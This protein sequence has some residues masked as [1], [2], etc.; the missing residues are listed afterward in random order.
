[1]NKRQ[2]LPRG[3]SH[4]YYTNR[5]RPLGYPVRTNR[6]GGQD[7]AEGGEDRFQRLILRRAWTDATVC[8]SKIIFWACMTTLKV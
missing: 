2:N 8:I 3:S 1:M 6:H 7:H 4:E 5:L